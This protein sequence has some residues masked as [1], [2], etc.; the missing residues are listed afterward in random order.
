VHRFHH[1]VFSAL[2]HAGRVFTEESFLFQLGTARNNCLRG[3]RFVTRSV[4][5]H[6]STSDIYVRRIHVR[7]VSPHVRLPQP[8]LNTQSHPAEST[9]WITRIPSFHLH[10]GEILLISLASKVLPDFSGVYPNLSA[11]PLSPVLVVP[12]LFPTQFSSWLVGQ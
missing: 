1:L 10:V 11:P 4:L 3:R 9:V 2:V 7:P 12:P 6:T 5:G 8:T